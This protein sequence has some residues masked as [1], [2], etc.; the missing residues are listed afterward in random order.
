MNEQS[1]TALRGNETYKNLKKNN[2]WKTHSLALHYCETKAWKWQ[3]VIYWN[4]S[5]T[6]M[7]ECKERMSVN[8]DIVNGYVMMPMYTYST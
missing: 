6:R 1:N 7:T 3:A 4:I 5:D 2:I 8:M